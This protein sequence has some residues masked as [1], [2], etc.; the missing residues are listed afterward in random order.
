MPGRT[1]RL[2]QALHGE[3]AGWSGKRARLR[4]IFSCLWRAVGFCVDRARLTVTVASSR[5][6]RGGLLPT[7][8]SLRANCGPCRAMPP[9]GAAPPCATSG[10]PR[11]RRMR[12][13]AAAFAAQS[14]GSR[15]GTLCRWLSPP[16]AAFAQV[17]L[18]LAT[19]LLRGSSLCGRRKLDTRSPRL[20][21]TDRNRLLGGS[22][23][24]FAL[25]Y[26]LNFL[27]DEFARLR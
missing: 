14:V 2:N 10:F 22:S 13:R 5:R 3:R 9:C 26:V 7:G 17:A 19:N 25:A 24:V 27:P 15:A 21:Q 6:F 12:N 20:R 18:S 1:K 23:A 11:E 16:A 4:L 8:T